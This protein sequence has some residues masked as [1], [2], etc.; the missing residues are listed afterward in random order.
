MSAINNGILVPKGLS[1]LIWNVNPGYRYVDF[2][3]G[4]PKKFKWRGGV[5]EIK[6]QGGCF[7][8]YLVPV[9]DDG[10]NLYDF[11]GIKNIEQFRKIYLGK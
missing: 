1:H 7:F 11:T 5:Y 4:L 10:S 3:D 2:I 9:R 6:F 8:P